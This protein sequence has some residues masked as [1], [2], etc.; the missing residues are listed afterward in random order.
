MLSDNIERKFTDTIDV[1]EWEVETEDGWT[2]IFQIHQTIP[3]IVYE[4]T[5]EN[6][7]ILYCADNH[8]VIDE[9]DEEIFVKHSLNSNI[10]TKYG[11]FRV[12]NVI[13]LD[14]EE[15]MYDL[16]VDDNNIYYTNNIL[17]H[18][19]ETSC[20]YI[21]HYALFNEFKNIYILANK[22]DT[23]QT[24]L[25]KLQSMYENLPY[26]LQQG[27]L[28]YNKRSMKFEN[29]TTIT[30]RATSKSAIRGNTAAL[31]Y[32]DE[33][34][35]IPTTI[36]AEFFSSVYPTIA[37]SETAKIM[38]S[39]TPKGMNH[40]Y[41]IWTSAVNGSS[42]YEW[43]KVHWS[44]VPGRDESYKTK[45]ISE[46]SGGV[47]E[48]NQEFECKFL[49]SG[50]TL[51]EAETLEK[52]ES[53]PVLYTKH[54]D[55]LFI[56]EMPK[57]D[58]TYLIIADVS[59]GVGRDASTMQIIDVSGYPHRQ[60]ARFRNNKVKTHVYHLY[61]DKVAKFFNDAFILVESNSIG[62]EVLNNLN[63]DTETDN[64]IWN[65]KGDDFGL[66]MTTKSKNIGCSRLQFLMENN[67]LEICDKDTIFELSTFIKKGNS[68]CAE[69][70]KNDDLVTPL[71]L[72]SYFFGDENMVEKYCDR[73]TMKNLIN[74][75]D[76]ENIEEDLLP[77]GFINN[78]VDDFDD[79]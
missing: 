75:Q 48:W 42:G 34:A 8:I 74:S 64:I 76:K 32:I 71:V 49:G 1:D 22:G 53:K 10:K 27:I 26:F 5:L 39:S 70:G 40:F 65:E 56:Y 13:N 78:G 73:S 41:S 54:D 57:E 44:E 68:Y 62:K 19:T 60:V 6:G 45:T 63:Y 17:S 28:V 15:T 9:N 12:V 55:N 52:L 79:D 23:A 50:G 16:S 7:E 30:A 4:M 29:G 69:D 21:L 58:H 18:N 25:A 67:H 31:I 37:S 33:T 51:I 43:L 77:F 66:R 59:E 72:Y 35:F 2:D 38:M 36:W 47:R 46:L 20:A 3:Y 24:I 11:V 61:I 14:Y